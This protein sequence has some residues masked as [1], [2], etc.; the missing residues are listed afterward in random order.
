MKRLA[1]L[2]F[3][4]WLDA[5]W[6]TSAWRTHHATPGT[7]TLPG[8]VTEPLRPARSVFGHHPRAIVSSTDVSPYRM[9]GHLSVG[10]TGTLIGPR[11]VLTAGHCVYDIEKE[12]WYA[13]LEFAPG[14]N[15]ASIPHGYFVWDSAYAT[16]GWTH[17]HDTAHDFALVVLK[18]PIGDK[19]GWM[20]YGSSAALAKDTL[21]N[22]AGYPGDKPS[23]TLWRAACP[24]AG[25]LPAVLEYDCDTYNGESGSAIYY[26]NPLTGERVI[27]GVHTNGGDSLNYG[28]RLTPAIV[29][30]LRAWKTAHP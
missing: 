14:R 18:E 23:G 16:E 26:Y 8:T 12:Q 21:V 13:R 9:M 1:L 10:C 15:G 30:T 19:V 20:A 22:V 11:H 2:V 27:Y 6:A 25:V 3:L 24:L 5:S 28:T 4:A 17:D 7:A 29:A